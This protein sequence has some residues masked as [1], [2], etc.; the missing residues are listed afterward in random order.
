M[1]PVGLNGNPKAADQ[2]NISWKNRYLENHLL[3]QDVAYLIM[4]NMASKAVISKSDALQ[5]RGN[6]IQAENSD[7]NTFIKRET[8]R[9]DRLQCIAKP[10]V[11]IRL[12]DFCSVIKLVYLF[13]VMVCSFF[14]TNRD[15][16]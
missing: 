1:F 13:F 3:T 9:E 2:I 16:F 8:K 7:R 5:R 6:N 12:L 11:K 4:W 10:T 14:M 15:T